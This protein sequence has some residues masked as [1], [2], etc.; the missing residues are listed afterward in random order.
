MPSEETLQVQYNNF[1]RVNYSKL[2]KRLI[3]QKVTWNQSGLEYVNEIVRNGKSIFN[4]F[5]GKGLRTYVDGLPT[6]KLNS[7]KTTPNEDKILLYLKAIENSNNVTIEGVNGYSINNNAYINYILQ[8][9]DYITNN[10]LITNTI[11]DDINNGYIY[12]YSPITN[13]ITFSK[14][15]NNIIQTKT[16]N[17]S[18][19]ESTDIRETTYTDDD[20]YE[21]YKYSFKD[22]DSD[23]Y[24]NISN[25]TEIISKI[26]IWFVNEN[27]PTDKKY[28]TFNS[29]NLSPFENYPYLSSENRWNFGK[30]NYVDYTVDGIDKRILFSDPDQN[31]V[32]HNGI[33]YKLFNDPDSITKSVHTYPVVTLR[34]RNT[35]VYSENENDRDIQGA[36]G[37]FTAER[38]RTTKIMTKA[39][40]YK[41]KDLTETYSYE[42]PNAE[43]KTPAPNLDK[44]YSIFLLLGIQDLQGIPDLIN[45]KDVT[46]DG[47]QQHIDGDKNAEVLIKYLYKMVEYFSNGNG[48]SIYFYSREVVH[49]MVHEFR[50]ITKTVTTTN[51]EPLNKIKYNMWFTGE[52]WPTQIHRD[53]T[54]TC[55]HIE[56]DKGNI[57][58]EYT[59]YYYSETNIYME[60]VLYNG[61]P[62]GRHGKKVW[63]DYSPLIPLIKEIV[64]TL[65]LQDQCRLLSYCVY[66]EFQVAYRNKVKWYETTIFQVIVTFAM[67]IIAMVSQQYYIAAAGMS[68]AQAGLQTFIFSLTMVAS[69]AINQMTMNP[70]AKGIIQIAL[71]A[72][73]VSQMNFSEMFTNMS[74]LDAFSLVTIPVQLAN[75]ITSAYY[76][77]QNQQLMF[78]ANRAQETFE[79]VNSYYN[80]LQQD[81]INDPFMIT[82]NLSFINNSSDWKIFDSDA[83]I[84]LNNCYK[85][86][87]VLYANGI[88]TW[89]TNK[90]QLRYSFNM[91]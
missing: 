53:D 84:Y 78:K 82:S 73:G 46:V 26:R 75:I 24:I 86:F 12:N 77:F 30:Y 2:S 88:D 23:E 9:K 47:V 20:G 74:V 4:A 65:S 69:M 48:D 7:N 83:G 72:I 50:N 6:I 85:Q 90:L 70:I 16:Y 57:K 14:T 21:A 5:Y 49:R 67:A 58:T 22:L 10:I 28:I 35:D 61:K 51:N 13:I 54:D 60:T 37:F 33:I 8:Y 29:D 1:P 39:L 11:F 62:D 56:E 40:G 34:F 41:L 55:I 36:E 31:T 44:I 18:S 89:H 32:S 43:E 63:T 80:Q 52:W 68:A 42:D 25:N 19:I 38:L 76:D 91:R 3:L 79:N 15:V 64:S 71:L 27:D 66:L 17:Y 81:L 45:G 87:D 59:F